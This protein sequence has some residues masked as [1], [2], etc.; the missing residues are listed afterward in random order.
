MNHDIDISKWCDTSR[1]SKQSKMN[2]N[3]SS[4]LDSNSYK[5]TSTLDKDSLEKCSSKTSNNRLITKKLE[6]V[7]VN[8]DLT[9]DME[10][11]VNLPDYEKNHISGL[12]TDRC[13]YVSE[14]QKSIDDACKILYKPWTSVILMDMCQ[15]NE[16]NISLLPQVDI[17]KYNSK[18]VSDRQSYEFD[19]STVYFDINKYAVGEHGFHGKPFQQLTLDICN[20]AIKSGFY[21]T[22]HGFKQR[23]GLCAQEF[24]CNRYQLYQGDLK[25]KKISPTVY[26]GCS[27]NADRNLSRGKEGLKMPRMTSTMK[28]LC[29]ENRCK[30]C[31]YIAYDHIGF[32]LTQGGNAVHCHHPPLGQKEINLPTR[33]PSNDNKGL[34]REIGEINASSGVSTN[35][36]MLRTGKYLSKQKI[37]WMT[38]LCNSLEENNDN[39]DNLNSTEKMMRYLDKNNLDYM[40]LYHDHQEGKLFNQVI[41]ENGYTQTVDL[42]STENSICL[43]FANDTRRVLKVDNDQSLLLGLAWV[44][45]KEVNLF[46]L[47]PEVVFCDVISD[48]NKDQ[49]PLLTCTGKDS[50]G[51]MFTFLRAF[52]PNEKQWVFR[53]IFSNVFPNFLPKSLLARVKVIITDGCVQEFSQVDNALTNSFVNACRVRCGF[54]LVRMGWNAKVLAKRH[55]DPKH[56]K[57]YETVCIHLKAWIYSWMRSSCETENEY[58]VSKLMFFRFIQTTHLLIKLGKPFVDSVESFVRNH[59]EPHEH[60]YCFYL[61]KRKRHFDEFCNS[62]HEGTN[63]GI[64]HSR[65]AV[66]PSTN[67]E[68]TLVVLNQNAI[69]DMEKKS[70]RNARNLYGVK[71]YATLNCADYLVPMGYSIIKTSW[72]RRNEYTSIR[73]SPSQW[74]IVHRKYIPTN[75][76]T[77]IPDSCIGGKPHSPF[78]NPKQWSDKNGKPLLPVKMDEGIVPKFLRVRIVTKENDILKC[79]C[80]YYERYGIPCSHIY[81]VCEQFVGYNKPSHHEVSVRWWSSYAMY[82]SFHNSS[83]TTNE[84]IN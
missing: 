82:A 21:L 28:P 16:Q 58:K 42:P 20:A 37:R 2:S 39:K 9:D 79:S 30:F 4:N 76:S 81:N 80:C 3:E 50:N 27:Y 71:L 19:G 84:K 67:I 7:S 64:R 51:K 10:S 75:F 8:I 36:L 52:L 66:G 24:V 1:V 18:K 61:R 55:V 57:F 12:S 23:Q 32:F 41:T 17:M 63:N 14:L 45:P 78:K 47:F 60:H 11:E 70:V 74:N 59:I 49:R 53:W 72:I 77:C 31:F 6:S 15:V 73:V 29:K 13:L 34:L 65:A 5:N 48:V 22:K 40:I 25:K 26:R 44:N 38:D 62:L 68:N 54:H 46:S 56:H 83:N 43:T 33:Y 35:L 69:K